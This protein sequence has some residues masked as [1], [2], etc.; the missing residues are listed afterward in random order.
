MSHKDAYCY[1]SA[2]TLKRTLLHPGCIKRSNGVDRVPQGW[3]SG[4]ESQ[5]PEGS[6]GNYQPR[7]SQ[8][9]SDRV[10]W[11]GA[12]HSGEMPQGRGAVKPQATCGRQTGSS[13]PGRIHAFLSQLL[14]V[15]KI[16]NRDVAEPGR[17]REVGHAAVAGCRGSQKT[18]FLTGSKTAIPWVET[19][20][21][22]KDTELFSQFLDIG[23][24]VS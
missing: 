18:G 2:V 19:N 5:P 21:R 16:M 24:T 4:L 6:R 15:C 22:K 20:K 13:A 12:V 7:V 14:R 3:D 10:W 1:E 11:E 17:W 9:E 8:I 23:V